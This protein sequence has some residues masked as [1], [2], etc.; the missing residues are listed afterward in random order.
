MGHWWLKPKQ[1]L[2]DRSLPEW[3]N[4]KSC[5][6]SK[7]AARFDEVDVQSDPHPATDRSMPLRATPNFAFAE[8]ERKPLA[9]RSYASASKQ[10]SM[11]CFLA[12]LD[13]VE[14]IRGIDPKILNYAD[15][16]QSC[17]GAERA[18]TYRLFDAATA[19]RAKDAIDRIISSVDLEMQYFGEDRLEFWRVMCPWYQSHVFFRPEIVGEHALF[20]LVTNSAYRGYHLVVSDAMAERIFAS[21]FLGLELG[22]VA[23][24]RKAPAPFQPYSWID[25]QQLYPA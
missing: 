13:L 19:Y 14:L 16:T 25:W 18:P 3:T 22:D 6:D 15:V 4:R 8:R 2:H 17:H 24:V 20:G 11:N 12:S 21:G 10:P 7:F 9:L 1:Y 5:Y 23:G